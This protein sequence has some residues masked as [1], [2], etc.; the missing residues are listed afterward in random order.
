MAEIVLDEE[1]LP[2]RPIS[3]V[4][5]TPH[6]GGKESIMECGCYDSAHHFVQFVMYVGIFSLQF[7]GTVFSLFTMHE[8]NHC[9]DNM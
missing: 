6:S 5:V 3:H 8:L 7:V 4:F 2:L 9:T 1:Y